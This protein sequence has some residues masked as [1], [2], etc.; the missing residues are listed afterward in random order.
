MPHLIFLG[1]QFGARS[2]ELICERTTVG[3]GSE[4]T[5]TVR[6]PSLSR[7]HCEILT[8]GSEVIVRDLGSRNG[9]FID[10]HRLN[11]AQ[12]QAKHGQIISFGNV[13]A[14]LDIDY[15]DEE[16]DEDTA[17]Y[18]AVKYREHEQAPGSLEAVHLALPGKGTFIDETI[19]L[20]A[21]PSSVAEGLSSAPAETSRAARPQL[22]WTAIWI[23]LLFGLLLSVLR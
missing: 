10:G 14:K 21:A 15:V 2:Y 11:R 7:E 3:R 1:E 17:F 20:R 19:Q 4:N 8:F 9:T 12:A 13:Q 16:S 23:I 6:D 5:L 22:L 18:D